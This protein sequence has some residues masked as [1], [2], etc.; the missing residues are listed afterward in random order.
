MII[1]MIYYPHDL[2]L[3]D[4]HGGSSKWDHQPHGLMH[5]GDDGF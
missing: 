5:R 3:R 2:L 1:Y 4:P